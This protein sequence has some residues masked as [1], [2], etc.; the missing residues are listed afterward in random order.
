MC[1]IRLICR[2]VRRSLSRCARGRLWLRPWLCSAPSAVLFLDQRPLCLLVP[3]NLVLIN[4]VALLVHLHAVG[5]SSGLHNLVPLV[6][7]PE[8]LQPVVLIELRLFLSEFHLIHLD[9]LHVVLYPVLVSPLLWGRLVDLV[10]HD[11]SLGGLIPLFLFFL[12]PFLPLNSKCL[13][14]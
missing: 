10:L 4:V 12:A 6:L 5:G 7:H 14:L 1:L 2:L 3:L 8:V 9:L 11:V 13:I